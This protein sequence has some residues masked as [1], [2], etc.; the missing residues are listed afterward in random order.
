MS[1]IRPGPEGTPLPDEAVVV[2]FAK[3]KG[4][5]EKAMAVVASGRA[6]ESM[7]SLSSKDKASLGKRLS[8]WAEGVT[9]P[10]RAWELLDK[11]PDLCLLIRL[12]PDAVRLIRYLEPTSERGGLDVEWEQAIRLVDG[13][14][15]PDDR[16]G[17]EGHA[18]IAGLFVSG[19]GARRR[20]RARLT[21]IARVATRNFG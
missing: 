9:T 19:D 18:G 13:C 11:N 16:D 15:V 2:R 6:R 1:A 10:A 14:D 4:L 20:L 7:F 12:R 3:T 17:A 5:N 21:E 8:V